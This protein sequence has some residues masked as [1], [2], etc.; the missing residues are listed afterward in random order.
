MSPLFELH[1]GPLL[2]TMFLVFNW[3]LAAGVNALDISKALARAGSRCA[4]ADCSNHR[5]NVSSAIFEKRPR[6]CDGWRGFDRGAAL[7]VLLAACV[8]LFGEG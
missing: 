5:K 3:R 4:Q 6:K 8:K 2:F 7:T 1:R